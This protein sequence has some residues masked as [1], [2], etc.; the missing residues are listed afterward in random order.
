[1]PNDSAPMNSQTDSQPTDPQTANAAPAPEAAPDPTPAP[2]ASSDSS[3]EPSSLIG[4]SVE[5]EGAGVEEGPA[6]APISAD[7]LAL[8]EGYA[9]PEELGA[10][11]LELMNN[12]PESRAEFANSILELHTQ[13]LQQTADAYAQQWEATQEEWRAA[14][15]NLPEIGGQNLQTSLGE[16]AKVLDRYGDKEVREAFALTG[17]GNHPAMV[18]FLHKIAKDLNEMPP[19]AG[20]PA[21]AAPRDRASRMFGNSA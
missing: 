6:P 17:A 15:Q 14:V 18:R 8:P 9:L 12:P 13:I 1:M 11:F 5:A 21:N 20:A 19:V 16:V 7:D 4:G 10:S 2:S 3:P